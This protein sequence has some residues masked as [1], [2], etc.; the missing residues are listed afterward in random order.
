MGEWMHVVYYFPVNYKAQ[1][2]PV[3]DVKLHL[4][5]MNED[6]ENKKKHIN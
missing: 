1:G 6:K 2:P 5:I 4:L 3:S